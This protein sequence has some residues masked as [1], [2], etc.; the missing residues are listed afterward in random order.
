VV[1]SPLITGARAESTGAQG[2]V[3]V[4]RRRDREGSG[5]EVE[6]VMGSGAGEASSRTWPSHPNAAH[7]SIVQTTPAAP[8]EKPRAETI[9]ATRINPKRVRVSAERAF[10]RAARAGG[11]LPHGAEVISQVHDASDHAVQLDGVD[12]AQRADGA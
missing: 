6:I 12:V 9:P 10:P 3:G 8:I 2:T 7:T 4:A 11:D 1:Y 5:R